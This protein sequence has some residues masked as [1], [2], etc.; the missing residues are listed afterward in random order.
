M[1][2]ILLG[3]PGTGKGTQSE[4]LTKKYGIP[5]ISTGDILREAVKN[6]TDLGKKVKKYIEKGELVPDNVI[7]DIVTERIRECDCQKG[8]LL[9][10]F[11]SCGTVL[12]FY[13]YQFVNCTV[14]VALVLFC[15]FYSQFLKYFLN[16]SKVTSHEYHHW[17]ILNEGIIWP[18]RIR[19]E[20]HIR[21]RSLLREQGQYKLSL[22]RK[23]Y[24]LFS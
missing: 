10:G 6:N 22:K 18:K 3:P 23:R 11:P 19:L 7:I 20:S 4:L 15:D 24:S 17:L 9:D 2:I 21:H 14:N 13:S 1:N 5:Q 12:V 16:V 8:F